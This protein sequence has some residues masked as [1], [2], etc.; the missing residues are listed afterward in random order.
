MLG[1][2]SIA[3]GA[4]SAV[5]AMTDHLLNT[6]L[7]PERSRLAAYYTRELARHEDLVLAS[8]AERVA[9]GSLSFGDAVASL[10]A[11]YRRRGG[12]IDKLAAA[13]DRLMTRLADAAERVE[14]GE[15][16][17]ALPLA[18]LR[19]DMHPLVAQGLGIDPEEAV[20][21]DQINGNLAGRRADGSKIAG[22][23]YAKVRTLPVNPKTGE[24]GVSMPI[25]SYD[26][27]PTPDKSVSV[28]SAFATPAEHAA[29]FNA[30]L[31]AA[32][33]AV[34]R[35]AT[36]IGVARTGAR[37]EGPEIAGHVGWYEFT[38]HTS[39]QQG[40]VA[41]DPDLHTHFL[42]PNA[43]FIEGSDRVG[44]L[45]TKRVRGFLFEADSFYQAALAQNLR[46]A[47][48]DA[49]LDE[50][51]GA[52]RMPAV[53]QAICAV[54]SKRTNAGEAAAR[55]FTQ[56]RGEVWE[57]LSP[58]QRS[59]RTKA[60]TQG[61]DAK[62]DKDD[63]A[64][65]AEW[66][67]QA[68]VAGWEPP[69]SFL[70]YGPPA[71]ERSREVRVREAYETAL[72]FVAAKLQQKSVLTHWELRTAAGRGLVHSGFEGL[73]DFNAVTALMRSEGVDQ[74]GTRTALIWGR[75]ERQISVTTA[76][77]E[78]EEREF[79]ALAKAAA[80]NR[81]GAIP[82][83]LLRR[84]IEDSGL[85]FTDEHG[86]AQ[87]AMI[88]RLGSGGAFG[89]GIAAAGAGKTTA[90]Q[91]LVAA[92]K[93][94]G[95]AVFGTALAWR[96]TDDLTD[97]DIAQSNL[98][99]FSLLID[100]AKAGEMNLGR[101]AVVVVDELSQLGT[102]QGLELL[103]LRERHGFTIVALGDDKQCSSIEA[104]AII[105]LTRKALGAE[106]VPVIITTRRQQTEREREI[107]GL[108]REGR[109][110]E[111][112]DMKRQDGTAEMVPGGYTEAVAR[113]AH[114]YAERLKATGLAPSVSA[115]TNRDAHEIGVA[116]RAERR[117]MGLVGPNEM[118]IKTADQ[119]GR[120]TWIDL[121]KG[122]HVRLFKSTGAMFADGKGGSIGR[123]A[124]VLEVLGCDDKGMTARS[125]KTG[126]AGR[127]AWSSLADK[128]GRVRIA[129]GDV[130]T[131][132]A[133]QGKTADEHINALPSGSKAVNGLQAY[134]SDTRHR[135]C[136]YIVTSE[137][138]ERQEVQQ[139]RPLNDR[140]EVTVDEQWGNVG[141]NFGYQ[142]TKDLATD[143]VKRVQQMRRGSAIAFIKEQQATERREMM[144]GA[145]SR[146]RE[147]VAARKIDA[148]RPAM[149]RFRSRVEHVARAVHARLAPKPPARAPEHYRDGPSIGR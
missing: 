105:E 64:N 132:V 81:S 21:R 44:S 39:R 53:P 127:V 116:I 2:A 119:E 95:R 60:A 51:T 113:V 93:E 23:V 142:P 128:A 91:P 117:A 18:V 143:M 138:A 10:T 28:A 58:D 45:N 102:R 80:Q 43:V 54:F 111:A 99:A 121:A 109:A 90:L 96:Q 146:A 32:R 31:D 125:L 66:R 134:T 84:A 141:R 72:P 12:D 22:K 61:L 137:K 15:P 129:Y 40:G 33:A 36:E 62:G 49:V 97:A 86:Q 13:E 107:V 79:I 34:A 145:P 112:L 73:A 139:R 104:G 42:I 133:A 78:A 5:T 115:P 29:I 19:P 75:D 11:G 24:Q 56:A 35:V 41:G 76:L 55:A 68:K 118:R 82:P 27:C 20:T 69:R 123:N 3:G 7:S 131:I 140:R 46:D 9:D 59:A 1:F 108:F 149:Q 114:L 126:R 89:V 25:G 6:T 94:Q 101:D 124:S 70:A 135:H 65:E 147:I 92:W 74:F 4:P 37:G 106:Q 103:R 77:H 50:R 16:A 100:A 14:R 144:G 83:D 17:V 136:S 57:D 8:H 88:E 110:K 47:G 26:F 98:K 87:R 85:G 120:E 63:V 30:H 48:F 38:H 67:R 148:I 71:P 130:L 122:D 52:A